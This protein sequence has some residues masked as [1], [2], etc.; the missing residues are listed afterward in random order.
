LRRRGDE[1]VD[2][3]S[4]V[5]TCTSCDVSADWASLQELKE[6]VP[7]VEKKSADEI[8]KLLK[9]DLQRFKYFKQQGV[10]LRRGRCSEAENQRIRENVADFLALTGI[11]SAHQLLFPQRYKDQEAEIRKLRVQHHFL[12]R[13]AEGVPRTCRQVNTRAKK[14]FDDR[15]HM[16][17]LRQFIQSDIRDTE[18]TTT[19]DSR[20]T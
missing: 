14:I 11:S 9:Y 16:G 19:E 3:G 20:D 7:D 6:F 4:A 10:P 5:L 2:I 13:I 17:R 18:S 12:E 1:E 8:N 15:N